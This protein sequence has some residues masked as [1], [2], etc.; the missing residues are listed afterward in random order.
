M[1]NEQKRRTPTILDAALPYLS[2]IG[3]VAYGAVCV[4]IV[5][6]A[7]MEFFAPGLVANFIAPQT[8][9]G[10]AFFAGALA[11]VAPPASRPGPHHAIA[12][13][14]ACVVASAVAFFAS[15][16]YFASVPAV[17]APLAYAFGIVVA[18]LFL[19]YV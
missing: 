14:A 19:A 3:R 12:Y 8:L 2:E 11:L 16:Y 1:T 17:Q 6:A 13:A 15:W 9:I 5:I 7:A 4:V 10:C 18:L